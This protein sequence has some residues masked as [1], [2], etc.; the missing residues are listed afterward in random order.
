MQRKEMMGWT[1]KQLWIRIQG[2][3]F[4]T[5]PAHLHK[6]PDKALFWFIQNCIIG[7]FHILDTERLADMWLQG[8]P[9]ETLNAI[10][11]RERTNWKSIYIACQKTNTFLLLPL[12]GWVQKYYPRALVLAERQQCC[13]DDCH[14]SRVA[15][16]VPACDEHLCPCCG[17]LTTE[18]PGWQKH[19]FHIRSKSHVHLMTRDA[20]ILEYVKME[21]ERS[22][23]VPSSY[24]CWGRRR[25]CA[26]PDPDPACR[27]NVLPTHLANETIL[28][29]RSNMCGSCAQR[30]RC[31]SC[32]NTMCDFTDPARLE[33]KLCNR[34]DCNTRLSC[35]RCNVVWFSINHSRM[36][37]QKIE[38]CD[39]LLC[40][41]C[42]MEAYICLTCNR[43]SNDLRDMMWS[44]QWLWREN[45]SKKHG[46]IEYCIRCIPGMKKLPKIPN[47]QLIQRRAMVLR[48]WWDR[49]AVLNHFD[50]QI[51]SRPM[52]FF[53]ELVGNKMGAFAS[54]LCEHDAG[55]WTL[56]YQNRTMWDCTYVLFVCLLRQPRDIFIKVLRLL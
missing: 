28:S 40:H 48:L 46:T 15:E 29:P 13:M 27:G 52:D 30:H 1:E 38:K 10:P 11:E 36:Y 22:C 4:A 53:K 32:C 51:K 47:C 41:S 43:T 37:K 33:A 39:E 5:V 35:R 19:Y 42:Q 14:K 18:D 21:R 49:K 9:P 17:S 54:Y 20:L 45:D 55:N 8:F 2:E 23:F 26:A 50:D 7:N 31:K 6:Y 24:W 25:N 56:L 12:Y 44:A 34:Q 3:V 16:N